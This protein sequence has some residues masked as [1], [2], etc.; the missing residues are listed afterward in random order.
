[1]HTEVSPL[2]RSALDATTRRLAG[3]FRGVFSD[4]TVARCVEDCFEQ[5][6]DRPTVG[7]N[8]TPIF[9]ERF[10]RER[11]QPVAQAERIVAKALPEVLFVCEHNSGRSQLAAGLAHK[12]IPRQALRGLADR[13]PG[14]AAARSRAP[15]PLR[16]PS[17]RRGPARGA[18][19][20]SRRMRTERPVDES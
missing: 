9:V 16:H 6:G 10:A 20:R 8:M 18:S 1:M 5:I 2:M 12:R 4:E 15:D 13:G 19:A 14:R 3:Q 11:L 17:P 7:L